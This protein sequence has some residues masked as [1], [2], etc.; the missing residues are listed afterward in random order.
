MSVL[1]LKQPVSCTCH[2]VAVKRLQ[3]C[4]APAN[5][6]STF[7]KEMQTIQL[8]SGACQRAC[9]LLGCC[10]IDGDACIVMSLFPNTAAK[11]VKEAQGIG[12]YQCFHTYAWCLC[13]NRLCKICSDCEWLSSAQHAVCCSEAE[14]S[15]AARAFLMTELHL[16][17]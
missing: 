5:V 6:E 9:C 16:G 11:R 17:L 3:T 2:Q 12:T 14:L 7:V 15:S 1:S 10:K 4:G 13:L 8:V